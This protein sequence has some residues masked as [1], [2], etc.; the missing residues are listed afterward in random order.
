MVAT[1]PTLPAAMI[2]VNAAMVKA[3]ASSEIYLSKLDRAA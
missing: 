2:S 3:A 1:V